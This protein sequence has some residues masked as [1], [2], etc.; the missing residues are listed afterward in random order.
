MDCSLDSG[1]V[2]HDPHPLAHGLWGKV[3][4]ELGPDAAGVA[5]GPGHLA[6]NHTEVRLLTLGLSG[7]GG[8]VLGLQKKDNET[9]CLD[10]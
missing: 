5:V 2:H 8:L 1:R 4:G 7:N 9:L 3:L 10:C 6:P